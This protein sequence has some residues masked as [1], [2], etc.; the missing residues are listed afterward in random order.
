MVTANDDWNQAFFG[1]KVLP[2][3]VLVRG[4]VKSAQ[5]SKLLA[6]VAAAAK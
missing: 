3:D 1:K 5:A 4:D 2:P 6:A